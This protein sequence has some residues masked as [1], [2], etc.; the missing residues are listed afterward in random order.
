MRDADRARA[1]GSAGRGGRP[2][3]RGSPAGGSTAPRACSIPAARS[4]ASSCSSVARSVYLDPEFDPADGRG[5]ILDGSRERGDEAKRASRREVAVLEL[6]GREAEQRVRRAAPR[7]GAR[8]AARRRWR[9][10]RPGTATSSSSPSAP[11]TQSSTPTACRAPREDATTERLAGA[12]RACEVVR[13]RPG[14]AFEELQLSTAARPRG[15]LRP[16]AP[17]LLGGRVFG[18]AAVLRDPPFEGRRHPPACRRTDTAPGRALREQRTVAA[19]PSI[20]R[21]DPRRAPPPEARPDRARS[22][23]AT[24]ARSSGYCLHQLGL[25]RRGRGRRADDVPERLPRAQARH[26]PRARVGVAVQDRPQRLPLA[27]PVVVAPEP[28]RVADRLRG[29]PGGDSRAE[30][31]RRRARSASRTCSSRCRR[32]SGAR[33]CCASGRA[34]PTARSP[35]SSSSRRAPSRRSSS[36][37]AARSRRASRSHRRRRRSGAWCAARTSATCSPGS[38]RSSSAAARRRRRWRRSSQ[39]SAP[40]RSSPRRRLSTTP[41]THAPAVPTPSAPAASLPVAGLAS[42]RPAPAPVRATPR[43]AA[44]VPAPAFSAG[45]AAPAP[46]VSDTLVQ[47]APPPAAPVDAPV[48]MRPQPIRGAAGHAAPGRQRLRRD[49]RAGDAADPARAALAATRRDTRRLGSHGGPAPPDQ[50]RRPRH[51]DRDNRPGQ[52]TQARVMARRR[53]GPRNRPQGNAAK[54]GQAGDSAR[55]TATPGQGH[56]QGRRPGTTG[57]RRRVHA[58]ARRRIEHR[59]ERRQWSGQRQAAAARPRPLGPHALGSAC[60]LVAELELEPHE[61]LGLELTHALAGQSELLADRLQ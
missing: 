8:R 54:A 44:R 23:S 37:P 20:G 10:S 51:A 39:S 61:R 45:A 36:A 55:A 31:A 2:P 12:E 53:P 41:E 4:A 27:A 13:A 52:A 5:A 3:S 32:T 24:R 35:P 25:A 60:E 38:S 59:R 9:S 40:A 7:R 22:T 43:P 26:R 57:A 11:R 49:R 18:R 46:T 47:T 14:A 29:P 58:T 28:G 15:A 56:G 33:S 6:T 17:R 21:A 30:P 50:G 19:V 48:P 16:A 42:V 1:P 34:S